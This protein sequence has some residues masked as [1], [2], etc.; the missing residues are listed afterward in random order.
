MFLN[1]LRKGKTYSKETTLY[2]KYYLCEE[3]G[4]EQLK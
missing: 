1:E 2:N 4:S 3:V